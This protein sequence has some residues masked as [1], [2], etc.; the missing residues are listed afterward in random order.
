MSNHL[1]EFNTIFSQLSTQKIAFDDSVKAMFLLVTL[2]KSWDTF[3]TASSNS[4]PAGSL[5]C[6]DVESS[7]SQKRSIERILL[8][9]E[10]LVHSLLEA[11]LNQ[12]RNL[13]KEVDQG[14]NLVQSEIW[15]AIIVARRVT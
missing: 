14:A 8:A 12:G 6:A 2:P 7:C 13:V 15:N 3:K 11:D 10:V 5:T 4:T 1:N 9:L